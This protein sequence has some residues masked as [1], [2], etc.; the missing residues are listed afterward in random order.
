M[1]RGIGLTIGLAVAASA[2]GAAGESR[3]V[4]AQ[5][6][7]RP[8]TF[9]RDIAPLLR[10]HCATCH[11][12]GGWGSFSV[13]D[14]R[15][16]RPRARLIA[17][18]V[19]R[20]VMP[21]WKPEPGHGGPFV[22]ERRLTDA[23]IDQ[24]DTWVSS[25]SIAGVEINPAPAQ[26]FTPSDWRLGQPDLV[27]SLP[28]PYPRPV[29]GEDT[30]RNFVLPIPI[31]ATRFVRGV[32]FLPNDRS[33]AH[34]A[35]MRIDVTGNSRRLDE[36]DPAPGYRGIIPSSASF[37]D[38]HFLGW[39]PGQAAPLLP[40]GMSWRLDPG[41]S[42]VVQVHIAPIS[43]PAPLTF[44]VAF[45]FTNTPPE[46]IPVMLR[47]G[48]QDIDIPPGVRRYV[49]TDS[50]VLPVDVEV[51][52]VQPHAH[53]LAREIH[54]IATLPDQS[55][56]E[57]IYIKDWD[58]HWQDVY[59]YQQPFWLPKG[60][61]LQ[62]EYSYDNSA[63]NPHNA[64]TAPV[65]V[66][67]GQQTSDEMGDLWIQVLPRDASS[68]AILTSDFK[69]KER[70]E[71]VV[72]YRKML[73]TAPQNPSLQTGLGNALLGI[74][75]L[76]EALGHFREVVRLEPTAASA[77]NNLASVLV[78]AG[79][80]DDAGRH[81]REAIA[82]DGS[83]AFA[84]NGLGVLLLAQGDLKG[85]IAQL[86]EAVRLEPRDP[87]GHNNLGIAWQKSG[88]VTSAIMHYREATRLA[89]DRSVLHYNLANALR[90]DNQLD[91]AIEAYLQTVRLEPGHERA[92]FALAAALEARDRYREAIDYYRRAL[93]LKPDPQT[94]ARL[95]WLLAV[96]PETDLS[97]AHEAVQL[98]TRAASSVR[99]DGA[100]L[101]VLAACYASAGQF[102]LAISTAEQALAQA[103]KNALP[104]QLAAQFRAR[105]ALYRAG[106]RFQLPTPTGS[107][108]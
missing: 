106:K 23:E 50:Y 99:D 63:G 42:L 11:R 59:R 8:L 78:S 64:V 21:P 26:S 43:D 6:R 49:V 96:A 45:Y 102:E 24:I 1:I 5:A 57:L 28:E 36:R 13:L 101:D 7:S 35:N 52:A 74:G 17:D 83:S 76:S 40:P 46:H 2:W 80:P 71:D 98:A 91:G 41:S 20:R 103:K 34:H 65:R 104:Q 55:R 94:M 66:R 54:G 4:P 47:I 88:S 92:H 86:A 100:I 93:G 108:Q 30:F 60:T 25:G 3:P 51:H 97:N 39:T 81:F 73:E 95:A 38:G 27:V 68:R 29:G 44:R 107:I 90:L 33:A 56:R 87:Q 82:L 31:S 85:A 58:F 79:L 89:P 14:Y 69:L 16:V 84:H 75:Q 77:H 22:G 61:T 9:N 48:R 32:E 12:P 70:A 72:G 53:R 62:M 19:R 105:L 18:V 15:E 10:E 37:P 67:Y